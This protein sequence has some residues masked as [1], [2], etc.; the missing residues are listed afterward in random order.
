MT[1]A[2][3]TLIALALLLLLLRPARRDFGGLSELEL[4]RY[5]AY[6]AKALA[7]G[8]W[9]RIQ[10]DGFNAPIGIKKRVLKRESNLIVQVSSGDH[11]RESVQAVAHSLESE[12]IDYRLTY[13]RKRRLPRWTEVRLQVDDPLMPSSCTHVI[14]QMSKALGATGDTFA[15]SLWGP[16]AP[17]FPPEDG[18]VI[19]H[20]K[21]HNFGVALGSWIGSL[22]RVFGPRS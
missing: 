10:V 7:D 19:P 6:G 20:P 16:F 1:T 13:S 4:Q 15:V 21:S 9:L 18:D 22:L 12:G 11:S 2:I 17:G 3:V 5:I 14:K 8:G